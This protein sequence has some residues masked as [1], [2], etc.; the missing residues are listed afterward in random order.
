MVREP[1]SRLLL[2]RLRRL[3]APLGAADPAGVLTQALER[4]FD[5]PLDDESYGRNALQPGAL[6][7]EWSFSEAAPA[8]LRVDFEPGGRDV[9]PADRQVEALKLARTA[10][11]SGGR[12]AHVVH[13]E[14]ACHC[15][16]QHALNALRFGAFIGLAIGPA[17]LSDAKIYYEAGAWNPEAMR[18]SL[19]DAIAL[20][21]AAI[22][23]LTPL[24]YSVSWTPR[25]VAERAYMVCRDDVWLLDIGDALNALGLGHRA[26]DLISTAC[27]LREGAFVL[28]PNATVLSL[29]EIP[30]GF[31]VKLEIVAGSQHSRQDALRYHIRSL[32]RQR[33]ESLRAWDRWLEAIASDGSSDPAISVSSI[34]V[35]PHVSSRLS[36]YVRITAGDLAFVRTGAVAS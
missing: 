1:A 20:A 3:A 24:L 21:C 32:L 34:S 7:I 2:D 4:S 26:P 35:T 8:A 22:P 29:R 5:R 19:R 28:P 12:G 15:G 14:R 16:R 36:V 25:G 6:P 13:F 9:S 27:T 30:G 31:E 10:I 17:G 18:P 11:G 33:P 23:G